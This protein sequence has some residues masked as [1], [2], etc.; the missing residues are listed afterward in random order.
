MALTGRVLHISTD[1]WRN[2]RQIAS[3]HRKKP[4]SMA[5][6]VS[7]AHGNRRREKA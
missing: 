1:A 4:R 6:G 2:K 5:D 7:R 3:I